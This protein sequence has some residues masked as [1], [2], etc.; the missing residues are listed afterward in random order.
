MLLRGDRS[1]FDFRE[2]EALCLFAACGGFLDVVFAFAVSH[3]ASNTHALP[4]ETK[5][6]RT[7]MVKYYAFTARVGL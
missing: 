1:H 3:K 6:F 5:M 7:G 4:A 2:R